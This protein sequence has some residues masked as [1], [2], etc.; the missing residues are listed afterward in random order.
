MPRWGWQSRPRPRAYLLAHAPVADA[1]WITSHR[2]FQLWQAGEGSAQR[3]SILAGQRS[4]VRKGFRRGRA[5]AGCRETI[6]RGTM[7]EPIENTTHYSAQVELGG[8]EAP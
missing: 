2:A 8:K 7:T 1:S 3:G 6:T 4:P 5:R